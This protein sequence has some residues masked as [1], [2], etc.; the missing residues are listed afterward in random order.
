MCA[1]KSFKRRNIKKYHSISEEEKIKFIIIHYY[2]YKRHNISKTNKYKNKIKME[3]VI[4]FVFL[5]YSFLSGNERKNIKR[6]LYIRHQ[7]RKHRRNNNISNIINDSRM[8]I[9]TLC[10]CM[11]NTIKNWIFC[12]TEEKIN[13]HTRY[14]SIILYPIKQKLL[15]CISSFSWNLALSLAII[16][17]IILT[18]HGNVCVHRYSLTIRQNI[19]I[20]PHLL[21][22]IFGALPTGTMWSNL[23]GIVS[24]GICEWENWTDQ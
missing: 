19:E 10:I 24:V 9:D 6:K 20:F 5:F 12:F 13:K 7:Q 18:A 2:C 3:I 14:I 1:N 15:F 21:N 17:H 23:N 4:Y 22:E 16:E 8:S 11:K